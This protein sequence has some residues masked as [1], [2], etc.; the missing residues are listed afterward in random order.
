MSKTEAR[1]LL[2]LI[3]NFELGVEVFETINSSVFFRTTGSVEHFFNFYLE[4][5]KVYLVSE[6]GTEKVLLGEFQKFNKDTKVFK[7]NT[8]FYKSLF[9][10]LVQF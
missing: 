8:D 6:I 3:F 10:E 1:K 9:N 2:L 7:Q 4:K 5:G